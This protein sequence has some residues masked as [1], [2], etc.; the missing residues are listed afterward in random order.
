MAL[1]QDAHGLEHEE[2]R[3]AEHREVEGVG[4]VERPVFRRRERAG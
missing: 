4:D 3:D 2:I 1:P